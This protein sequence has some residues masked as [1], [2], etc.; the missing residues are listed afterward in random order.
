MECM[1]FWCDDDDDDDDVTKI[2]Q[3]DQMSRTTDA[4][5]FKSESSPAPDSS[6]IITKGGRHRWRSAHGPCLSTVGRVRV[7]FN[8]TSTVDSA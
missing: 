7:L 4:R 5:S 3:K 1:R 8:S 2:G 6:S